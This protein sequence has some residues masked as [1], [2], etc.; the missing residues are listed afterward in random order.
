[1][2]FTKYGRVFSSQVATSCFECSKAIARHEK[3]WCDPLV[4]AACF[5][6]Y[7]AFLK[8]GEAQIAS[9]E[10]R[11]IQLHKRKNSRVLN[12]SEQA[13]FEM[14]QKKLQRHI[15]KRAVNLFLQKLELASNL[16]SA[17]KIRT[18]HSPYPCLPKIKKGGNR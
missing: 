6:C 4:G 14:L 17:T 16:N 10:K 7:Q 12:G 11:L 9:W 18:N 5:A 1:M 8:E 2:H 13:E 3:V 15:E